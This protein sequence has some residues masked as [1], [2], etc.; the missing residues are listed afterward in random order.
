VSVLEADTAKMRSIYPWLWK[1][2]YASI[3]GQ[4]KPSP[5]ERP[6]SELIGSEVF[7]KEVTSVK[8]DTGK[9]LEFLLPILSD[10]IRQTL[11]LEPTESI[12][13]ECEM[14]IDSLMRI[15]LRN[16]LQCILGPKISL[17]VNGVSEAKSVKHLAQ[18]VQEIILQDHVKEV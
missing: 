4:L 2:E 14:G 17:T 13:T 1:N 7:L 6:E 5:N 8:D 3:F 12:D 10:V 9:L 18:R 15:E 11:R 16:I